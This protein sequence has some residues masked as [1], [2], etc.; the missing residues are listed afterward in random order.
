MMSEDSEPK[1]DIASLPE[2]FTEKF[3]CSKCKKYLRPPIWIVCDRGHNV[4]DICKPD[5]D[6]T[7]STCTVSPE[8]K[9]ISENIRNFLVEE[10]IQVRT[11]DYN[12]EKLF[13]T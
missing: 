2:T 8:C 4:C 11:T 12:S 13:C 3:K 1:V 7:G 5:L 9:I 6:D 10:M